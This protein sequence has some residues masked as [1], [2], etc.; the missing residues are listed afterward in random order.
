M[1]VK[2][3]LARRGRKKQAIYDVVVADARA[4]R[5]G[6]FIEKL[7]SY[8]PNSDPAFISID[9]ERAFKWVM[10]GAQP[11]DTAR[12]IL[13]YRG[14]MYKKHLQ[15]GV[16]KGAITQE[17]ADKKFEAWMKEKEAKVQGKVDTLAKAKDAANKTKLEAEAKVNAARAE[18]IAKKR[19]A[20]DEA[21]A[22]AKAEA[23]AAAAPAE[24]EAPA[25]E[26]ATPA[27]EAPAAEA[28]PEA[29]AVEEKK[30][31]APKAEAKEEAPAA[32]EK[33]AEEAPKEEDKAAE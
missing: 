20:I 7:G 1:A 33:P 8:N 22:A 26:A 11:T 2:I 29:P 15:V 3:R 9:E 25:T 5:D 30:E 32:E 14:V 21:E 17:D 23:E 31:E 16:N 6:R 24:E 18:E 28:A 19:L 13:S 4:P 12:A 27:E 10:D